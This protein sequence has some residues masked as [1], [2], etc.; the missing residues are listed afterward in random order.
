MSNTA[1]TALLPTTVTAV[2]EAIRAE[3]ENSASYRGIADDDYS[4]RAH[5][6]LGMTE[7][8]LADANRQWLRLTPKAALVPELLDVL[9]R[10]AELLDDYSDVVDGDDGP[11]PNRAMSLLGDV[12]AAIAKAEAR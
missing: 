7:A 2:E 3:A 6:L 8:K 12:E 1:Q 10:C 5:F 4:G 11:L 9:H